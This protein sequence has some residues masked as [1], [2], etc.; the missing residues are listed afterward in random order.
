M[1]GIA[2]QSKNFINGQ[3][4]FR[5]ESIAAAGSPQQTLTNREACI[6]VMTGAVLPLNT[7]AVIPYEQCLIA[8][9][10]AEIEIPEIKPMQNIHRKGRDEQKGA[11]LIE[12]NTRITPAHIGVLATVGIATPEVYTLPKIALCATGDEL[13]TIE[14]TPLPHQIR[15]SNIYFLAADLHKENIIASL[16]HLPDEKEVMRDKLQTI[17]SAHDVVILSGAVSKGKYDFLPDVLADLGMQTLFHRI[18]QK[19]GKPF[20]IGKIGEKI[21]FGFPGNPVST[22]VCYHLYCKRWLYNCIQNNLNVST[23]ILKEEILGS[24]QLSIHY[25]GK[26]HHENGVRIITPIPT[27]SS[28]DIPAL[29]SADCIF[30]IPAGTP[31]Y[32]TGDVVEILLCR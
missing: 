13:V 29:L 4:R 23:G 24:P 28:G 8:D 22:F 3:R 31:N 26:L 16:H 10:V 20:L 30:T 21:I 27:S 7:D 1:D 6:E 32:K 11:L 25:L 2:I 19:P 14:E 18:A 9:G 5:I 17:L 15:Q 12:Q